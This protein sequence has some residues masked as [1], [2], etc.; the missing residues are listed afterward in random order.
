MWV[1]I[2]IVGFL[3]LVN[4]LYQSSNE[5]SE[6]EISLE[7]KKRI[8]RAASKVPVKL[9]DSYKKELRGKCNNIFGK[10]SKSV[11]IIVSVSGAVFYV[12]LLSIAAAFIF[13]MGFIASLF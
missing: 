10:P 11:K 12:I 1:F 7:D 3:L 4:Y 13:F 8:N 6:Y 5:T 2:S 9:R